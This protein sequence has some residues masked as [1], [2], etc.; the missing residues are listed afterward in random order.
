MLTI[1]PRLSLV[2]GAA[3]PDD[4]F[5]NNVFAELLLSHVSLPAGLAQ[6][7]RSLEQVNSLA[8][9]QGMETLTLLRWPCLSAELVQD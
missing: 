2:A 9:R 7:A 6:T 5:K 4:S 1:V 3:V 8:W